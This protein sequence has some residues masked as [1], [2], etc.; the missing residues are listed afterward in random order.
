MAPISLQFVASL[1]ESCIDA[2][3]KLQRAAVLIRSWLC[4]T[5]V[6]GRALC[7]CSCLGIGRVRLA[8]SLLTGVWRL[9]AGG[10]GVRSTTGASADP[11]MDRRFA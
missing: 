5:Q 7:S 11:T 9:A 2:S 1:Y 4:K 10:G 6:L 8:S 3:K